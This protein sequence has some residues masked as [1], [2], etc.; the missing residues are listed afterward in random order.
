M[1][2]RKARPLLD[3]VADGYPDAEEM[4]LAG[5]VLVD[6]SVVTNPAARIFEDS[7]IVVRQKSPLRG[8]AKLDAAL[9]HFRIRVDGKT[10]LDLGAAAGGFTQAALERGAA[11]VFAVD[12][13]HGQLLGSLRQDPRVRNLESTNLSQLRCADLDAVFDLVVMDLSYLSLDKALPQIPYDCVAPDARLVA[14]VK[15][16]F[17][18]GLA[19][20]PATESDF[21]Q[22]VSLATLAA[23]K[24]GWLAIES[25]RS[26]VTGARGAVEFFIHGKRSMGD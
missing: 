4:I 15:P 8:K 21:T 20:P 26:P 23:Q 10:V 11:L 5:E 3:I 18:L 19:T 12:V 13:G 24:T 25:M 22:A 14:L 7:A 9:D 6:G 16:M 1:R 17:E 2:K